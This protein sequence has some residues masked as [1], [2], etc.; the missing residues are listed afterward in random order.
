MTKHNGQKQLGKEIVDFIFQ[1]GSQMSR[2]VSTEAQGESMKCAATDLFM[3]CSACFH[4]APRSSSPE[5][6]PPI[7]HWFLPRIINL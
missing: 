6:A 4:V 7:L 5:V 2:E 1:L 3:A